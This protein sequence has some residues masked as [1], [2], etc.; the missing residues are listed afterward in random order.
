MAISS[1][2][3][4]KKRGERA[5]REFIHFESH[6]WGRWGEGVRTAKHRPVD[7]RRYG[8]RSSTPRVRRLCHIRNHL[9]L[10]RSS[11]T[12]NRRRV[13]FSMLSLVYCNLGGR[14]IEAINPR[15]HVG[16][17]T[18]VIQDDVSGLCHRA[19]MIL[20]CHRLATR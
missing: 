4:K 16:H 17:V 8:F 13:A 5:S 14:H 7:E 1:S 18:P 12:I 20:V 19:R 2:F 15:L 3:I 11:T 6:A 9:R 10:R